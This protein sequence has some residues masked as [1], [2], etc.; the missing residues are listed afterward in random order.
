MAVAL[1]GLGFPGVGMAA[2]G[3]GKTQPQGAV[4]ARPAN[5]RI[6]VENALPGT[7]EW[8]EV[9]NH[10]MS[11]LS[12]FTGAVSVNAGEPMNVHVKSTGATLSAKLYRLGYYQDQGARLYWEQT[13]IATP[14]QPACTRDKDTGLVQ[15]PWS[16]TFAIPTDANWI[17]GIYLLRLDSNQGNRFFVYFIVRNDGYAADILAME[18]TKTN[19][20]YNRYGCESLYF[21]GTAST[22]NNQ[23][24][25][26]VSNGNSNRTRAYK[27]SFDR[28]YKGGAGTGGL[29]T[30][31]I[32]MIRWLEASGYDVTYISDV[33]RAANPSILL[34]HKAYLVM[35]HDE[36]WTWQEFDAVENAVANG[37]NVLFLSAN[38]AYWRIRMESSSLGPNRV[39]VGYK[40]AT[41]DPIKSGPDGPTVTFR[42]LNRS[43]NRLLGTGY[44]SYYDDALYN[45][46]W[47][48]TVDPGKWYWDCTGLRTGDIVNNIVGEEWNA[49]LY[50]YN[51]VTPAGIELLSEGVAYNDRGVP[52]PQNTTIYT[53]PSGAMVFA[54]GSIH[55]SWGLMDHSYSNQVFQS[56]ARSNDA[57]ARIQ[58]LT[59]NILD[60]FAGYWD[61]APRGC[62][63]QDFYKT[64]PRPTRT[65]MPVPPTATGTL[66]TIPPTRTGTPTPQNGG[67]TAT[68]TGTSIATNTSILAN[69]ATVTRTPTQTPTR[70]ATQT[71]V[72]GTACTVT[73]PA[74]DL[75]KDIRD[76]STTTSAISVNATGTMAQVEVLGLSIEHTYASDVTA[77]LVSPQGTR[78]DLFAAVCGAGAWMESNTGFGIAQSAAGAMGSV[79]PPGQATYKPEEAS[80]AVFV[81]QQAQGTWTL[82]VRDGGQY[83]EGKLHAWQL[84]VTLN[85]ASCGSALSA[86]STNTATSTATN[87]QP[88]TSTSTG[89]STPTSTIA[90]SS[91][92]TATA[93]ATYT[94]QP[95]D[96]PVPTWTATRTALPAN[97]ATATPQPTST[98]TRTP[99]PT[100]TATVAVPASAT[101]TRTSTSTNTVQ[102]AANTATRTATRTATGTS[103]SVAA[104]TATRTATVT[105]T[106]TATRTPTRT[107]TGTATRTP[108]V[109][110]TPTRTA[111]GVAT[112]V[113]TQTPA[114]SGSCAATYASAD[115]PRPLADRGTTFSALTVND[116]G[117]V[118]QVEVRG[119]SLAHTY[120]SDMTVFLISPQ[121]ARVELFSHRC[122]SNVW[123]QAN[124]GFNLKQGATTA[125]GATCPPG[126]G[127]YLPV[128][129][130]GLMAGQQAKGTWKL[131]VNDTGAYDL[132]T[133]HA[134]NLSIVYSNV[135]CP[136]GSQAHAN[137]PVPTGTPNTTF[138][139][140][141]QEDVFK[142]YLEWMASRGYI[143]GYP[144][145]GD[146]EPCPGTYFRPAASV[147]RGQLLKMVVSATGWAMDNPKDPTFADVARDSAF[148]IFVETAAR[149][150]IINGYPC[151]SEAEPCDVAGRPYFRAGSNITRGQ[152][153]KVMALALGLPA[154][155][156]GTET[157]ADVPEGSPFHT[158]VEAM[159]S[160][161]IVGGYTC[162]NTGEPCDDARRPYFRPSSSATRGQVAKFVAVGY[163]DR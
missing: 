142:P 90:P 96:T 113:A 80:L 56:Y 128:G 16:S 103:T 39:V 32:E 86:T 12:A 54:A 148:Y 127:T 14:S 66:P 7:S 160:N 21:S 52:Y 4:S 129:N 55:W 50:N 150:G 119:L 8:A 63:G 153:S 131:E 65:P 91:T 93:S 126:S 24:D 64:G 111:T 18:P 48:P 15:C 145:G 40:D 62:E 95:T 98:A 31:D 121:G 135:P 87:T 162:G 147:T 72:Q 44:M 79:C 112:G 74:T 132:G 117:T 140:V 10:D 130:L 157:F 78:V 37:V 2:Q 30:H 85:S 158:Y 163:G 110:R 84:R 59:A 92:R 133:L 154:P 115:V 34:G 26:V 69:T 155:A 122:G 81:G 76:L 25:G 101:A 5:S 114:T 88:P 125:M 36:Y 1:L 143:S 138:G 120:A 105:R 38:E 141:A 89:T 58:Q 29:F 144:C 17:S 156:A 11:K 57:D 28:P 41:A 42:N 68:P 46:P 47:Q 151:G 33:D 102:P 45:M 136:V 20:A 61:G 100:N 137:T 118:A 159:S 97:T 124:T 22:S 9:G 23:C 43:E 108:T 51:S 116:T 83:D 71:P 27:V 67:N 60:R 53:A 13:N 107:A 146:A 149:H 70:T 109:T 104:N 82:E 161:H 134:W 123:T 94:Y 73:F 3:E 6:A 152:L 106:G 49:I 77:V 75:P 139:D 35:G 99:L 19:Q